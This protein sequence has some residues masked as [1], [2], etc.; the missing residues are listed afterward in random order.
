M[1]V[2]ESSS[3]LTAEKKSTNYLL[4]GYYYYSQVP[5]NG[6]AFAFWYIYECT[7]SASN[8][9]TS[10]YKK[11]VYSKICTVWT[12]ML[13]KTVFVQSGLLAYIMSINIGESVLNIHHYLKSQYNLS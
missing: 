5:S 6:Y 11:D 10:A 2:S 7:F 12:W 3:L 8:F 9:I 1:Q 4:F 13:I